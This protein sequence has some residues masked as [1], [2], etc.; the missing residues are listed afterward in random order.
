MVIAIVVT[1]NPELDLLAKQHVALSSQVDGFVYVDNHSQELSFISQINDEKTEIIQNDSNLGLAK[2]QNQGII[3]ARQ[4]GADFVILFDQDS[5][6]PVGFVASLQMCYGEQS[7]NYQVGL[8]G[9]AIRNMLKGS[10]ENEPGSVFKGMSIK[11]IIVGNATE[12]SYCI[13]SGSLIPMSV[14]D[15]V[16]GMEEKLFIDGL[17]LEWCLRAR[18]KGY[19]IYQTSNT[20]LEH[21]LGDGTSRRIMSHSP[22]REYYIMR[23]AVWMIKRG[24]IPL[25][26]RLRKLCLSI[27]RLLQSVSS[28][29]GKY[30]KADLKGILDGLKL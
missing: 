26:Y 9:P 10:H 4:K 12:V 15:E 27:G 13:A 14:L 3:L 30:I 8:V 11:S 20:F 29:S 28:F 6:P 25:G 7:K 23:N 22:I 19:K 1:Y 17:D 16:G 5:I 21:C 18:S 2:A 24:N